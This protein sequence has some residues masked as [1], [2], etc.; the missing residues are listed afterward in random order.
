[1]NEGVVYLM[2]MMFFAA[3]YNAAQKLASQHISPSLVAIFSSV[4]VIILGGLI[5]AWYK[6]SNQPLIFSSR[7]LLFAALVGICATGIE[8]FGVLGFSKGVPFVIANA[9]TAIVPTV[10]VIL[11]GVFLFNEGIT[12]P[13]ILA[14]IFAA[15]ASYLA[16]VS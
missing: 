6:I 3:S 5:T 11:Y 8:F 10:M 14:L 7:G 12:I 9:V 13:R 4:V 1:M 2:I 16:A 15:L